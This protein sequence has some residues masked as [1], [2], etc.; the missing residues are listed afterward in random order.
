MSDTETIWLTGASGGLGM[1]IAR[2]LANQ[3]FDLAI[4]TQSNPEAAKQ[5]VRDLSDD[6]AGTII[7]KGNLAEAGIAEEAVRKISDKLAPPFALVHLAGPFMMKNV[8]DHSLAD[9]ETMISGNL[10]TFFN[11]TKAVLPEMRSAGSGRIISFGMVGAQSTSPMRNTGPHLAAKSA[12]VSLSKTW[13]IEEAS[14]GITFNTINPGKIEAKSAIREEADKMEPGS[15]FPMGHPG[16]FEDIA[17]AILFLLSPSAR[18]I[19]GSVIDV[20]GGWMGDDT[21]FE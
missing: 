12:V 18:Y 2:Y 16:S 4:H 8:S 1:G 14:N 15:Q 3:N 10:T 7:T 19:T 9:L 13:A 5:I 11:A 6:G 21:R 17:D 20:A